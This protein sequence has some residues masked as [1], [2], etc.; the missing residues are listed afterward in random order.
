MMRSDERKKGEQNLREERGIN[1]LTTQLPSIPLK[2]K[3]G[4]HSQAVAIEG[5]EQAISGLF[6]KA[7]GTQDDDCADTFL[8]QVIEAH[9]RK[10]VRDAADVLNQNL[11][12]LQ[13]I[14]PQDELEGMLAV[15]MVGIHNLTME[16]MSRATILDQ[17]VEGV[18]SNISRITK[19]SRTFATLLEALNRHRNKGQQ[20]MTVEHVH[21]NQGG[22]AIIGTVERG[23]GDDEK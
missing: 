12:I 20:K 17:T 6:S 22:Q 21:I 10:S 7:F 18:S 23:E 15:Q 14:K 9:P 11:P 1:T 4:A 19:L 16:M 13:A 2:V 3:K 5:T 8:E